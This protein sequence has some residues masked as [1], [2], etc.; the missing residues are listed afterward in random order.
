MAAERTA[1]D[2]PHW[3]AQ[4]R[5]LADERELGWLIGREDATHRAAYDAGLSADEHLC[6]LADMAQWRGCGCGG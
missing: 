2:F 5:A 1:A 4:L 3:L 6:G